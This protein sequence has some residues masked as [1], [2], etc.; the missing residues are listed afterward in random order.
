MPQ[1]YY[2]D[3]KNAPHEGRPCRTCAGRAFQEHIAEDRRFW[4][5]LE[6]N[7]KPYSPPIDEGDTSDLWRDGN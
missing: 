3:C 5:G 6:L 1:F 7:G 2:D 4:R